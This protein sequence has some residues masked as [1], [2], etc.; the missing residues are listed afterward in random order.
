MCAC[1]T[2][3]QPRGAALIIA[4]LVMAVLLMAGTTFLTISST[5]SQ[6]ALNQR[7]S[8]QASLLA[9][10]AIHKAIAQLNA[11]STYT[12]E[13]GT[14]L[15][16]GSFTITATTAA[17]CAATS[18]RALV[19]TSSVPV[20]GGQ[21][22]VVLQATVDRVSYPYRW[23][24]FAAVPN[25]VVVD[26]RIEKE[27]WLEEHG[28]VD[29]FDSN[30]GIYSTT[31]NRGAGGNIGANG[32]I[33]LDS[34]AEI[35]GNVRAGDALHM[36]SGVTVTGAQATN[37]SPSDT[38]PGEP[39]PSVTPGTAPTTGLTVSSG[40]YTLAAGTYY[41]TTLTFSD[42]T[43]L[44][45]SGGLVTIYVTGA[46]SLG[47]SVTLGTHPDTQL[48]IIAKSDGGTTD[49]VSF[50]A[51]NYFTLYGSL[52]GKNTN[53]NI[54]N[55]AQIY[56]SMIGRTVHVGQRAAVHYDQAMSD[57]EI[58]HS[59]KFNIRRGTWREVRPS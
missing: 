6:I 33:T 18:A 49:F 51:G 25:Q 22:Q 40:T 14:A 57:Q 5:E 21:A 1:G 23:A 54:G 9:E 13:T 55:D 59:G 36:G 34:D 39:F 45:T 10:A 24:G 41:Y 30:L 20:R 28:S 31:T 12:G 58:C 43:S 17:G 35:R 15:S 48:R 56:G 16:T 52:Y 3:K 19:A 37:L 11:D 53:I 42:N 44:A 50:A 32:D 2:G 27:T 8:V 4:M 47:N 7:A 26:D 46:V 29:S 38:S